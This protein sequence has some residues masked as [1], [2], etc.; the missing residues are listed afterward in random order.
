VTLMS[1]FA[2]S[3]VLATLISLAAAAGPVPA[4]ARAG[5]TTGPASVSTPSLGITGE[6][7][8]VAATS[9]GSAWA[10]GYSGDIV[11]RTLLLHTNGRKWSPVISPAPMDGQLNAVTAVSPD[12]VWAVGATSNAAGTI[13]RT[14]ILHW[15]GKAWSRLPGSPRI[16]G[17]LNAVSVSGSVVW[18]VGQR[19][20]AGGPLIL[21]LAGGRW[22]AVPAPAAGNILTSVATTGANA[23][24]V[25][26]D[27]GTDVNTAVL[28]RWNGAGWRSVAFPLRAADNGLWGMAAA[29]DGVVWAV[30]YHFSQG[31]SASSETA[32]SMQWNGTS[33][34]KVSVSA[35][36]GSELFGVAHVPGGHAW[37]VGFVWPSAA[38][39]ATTL[40]LRWTGHAWVRVASPNP[41]PT[42][43]LYAVAAT[44]PRDAWA[45]GYGA[46]ADPAAPPAPLILH[47]NGRNWS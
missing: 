18:A 35:P 12:N 7:L 30:G 21:R 41:R 20:L 9:P 3:A 25:S 2:R 45:V 36:D 31:Q 38:A 11:T 27:G 23:A 44:S 5:E 43:R 16:I 19:T 40:T 26:G 32:R 33:W 6:L 17:L 10:V 1:W 24:W 29:P 47:W 15:N 28:L 4:I 37:A 13:F 8:G 14:L 22:S 34:R 39:S 46:P 42:D